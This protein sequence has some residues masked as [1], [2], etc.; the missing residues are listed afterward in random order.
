MKLIACIPLF[1]IYLLLS[2]CVGEEYTYVDDRDLKPGPGLL[3]GK[4]GVITVYGTPL[5][6]Q[7]SSEKITEDKKK[8]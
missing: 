5:P 3:S 8:N 6:A 1:C 7:E 2:G 4:D